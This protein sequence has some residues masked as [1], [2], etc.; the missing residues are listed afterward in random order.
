M[1]GVLLTGCSTATVEETK[2]S[3][4]AVEQTT[5]TSPTA[6]AEPAAPESESPAPPAASG[7]PSDVL[8]ALE[9]LSET[10]E[11]DGDSYER[12]YFNHWV[13]KNSTSCDTRFAVLVEESTVKTKISGCKVLSGN[14]VSSYDNETV[15][16]PK[17]L[18]ID[19]MVPLKESWESG[20]SKWDD[21][22]RESYANDM[23][24][25]NSLVAVTAASNRSKSAGDP[26]DWLPPSAD[27]HCE[28]VAHW[29]AVKTKWKL[30]IDR[31]EKTAIQ[32]VLSRCDGG[33]PMELDAAPPVINEGPAPAQP[34]EDP[35]AAPPV[36]GTGDPDMGSCSAAKQAGYGPYTKGQP[37]YEYYRDGDGDGTVCE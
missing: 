14:W 33:A 18:D 21:E 24:Y 34:A 23:D 11:Q 29:V 2:P 8:T 20:A 10:E 35:V 30:T 19:H 5:E 9:A 28:Y 6:T 22:T 16:D 3:P 31:Q 12:D 13:K 7:G 27:A 36:A 4:T 32:N 26:A 17:N 1:V 37:E 15:T 25:S